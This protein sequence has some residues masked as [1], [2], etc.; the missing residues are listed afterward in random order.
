MISRNIHLEKCNSQSIN[1]NHFALKE[2][3]AYLIDKRNN[4]DAF[5]A[6]YMKIERVY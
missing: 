6:T 3:T 4:A 5:P 2:D 1:I